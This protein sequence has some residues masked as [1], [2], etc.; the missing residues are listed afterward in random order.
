MAE[1]GTGR[2]LVVDDVP[3]NVKLLA[4]L[5]AAHGYPVDSAVDGTAALQAISREP[6]AL[7]LLDV[8]MPGMDGIDVL[9]HIRADEANAMLP[10]VM[11][12]ALEERA[13]R[14]RALEAG[15]DDFVNK[16][17]DRHELL[18]RVRS[19]LRIKRLYEQTR[20]M[21]EEL[22]RFNTELESRVAAQVEQL[23]RLALLKRFFSPRL[24][25]LLVGAEAEA[26]LASHR[27]EIVVVF[28]DLRG[29]SA[30]TDEAEPE[31]VMTALAE[32]HEAM[33]ARIE[34]AEGTLERFIG[35]G[36]VVFFNDPLPMPDAS[37]RALDMALAMQ[38][39]FLTLAERWRARGHTLGLGIGVA[40]GYATLGRIGFAGRFDYG[41]IGAVTNLAQRLCA[42]ARHGEILCSRAVLADA[43]VCV[44]SRG[45]HSLAG[46]A[47][48][49]EVLAVTG[50]KSA[51]AGP[52]AS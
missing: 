49:V 16:P 12:T 25:E 31:E 33:G 26:V 19:L 32:F 3:T 47:R 18:A 2:I 5:L 51:A 1:A 48:P 40:R 22:R 9:V 20:T 10:V 42:M 30:F 8:M 11:V 6:P 15:A 24:A 23:Q 29:Y 46:F 43:D 41:S 17:V 45:A 35:D 21:G 27:R 39:D 7:V 14:L 50:S 34:E 38:L 36:I 37:Q 13:L 52:A 44:E 4:D 28:L